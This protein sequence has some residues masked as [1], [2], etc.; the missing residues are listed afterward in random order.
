[1]LYEHKGVQ[2]LP[3]VIS[4]LYQRGL[5]FHFTFI[6]E[7]VLRATLEQ[8]LT[9]LMDKDLVEFSGRIS[10]QEVY[11]RLS[12]T[13]I[14][15]YPTH[16]DAFGLVIAEAMI[17]GAV[18]VVT[19]LSGVTDTI[20]D[21]GVNGYLIKQDDI[22]TFVERISMLCQDGTLRKEMSKA[23]SE[24]SAVCFSVETMKTNYLNYLKSLLNNNAR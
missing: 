6:G 12:K 22:N 3:E 20:V 17:N 4:Q 18:P 11:Q 2:I 13:D 8:S 23:A 10:A 7:G 9:D 24:K 15:V 1:M 19:L 21:D 16:L 14:F 5:R